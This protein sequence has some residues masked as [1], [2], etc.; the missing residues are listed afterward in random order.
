VSRVDYRQWDSDDRVS[1]E[2]FAVLQAARRDGVGFSVTDG[3]RTLAEQRD[4][5]A[6]YQRFGRPLAARPSPTAPHIRTGRPDHAIDVNA[7]DGGAGRL[8]AWLRRNGAGATFPVPGEPWHV[9]VPRDDLERL[10]RKV[11]DPFAGFT[12]KE[13]RWI[14][15]YDE[16]VRR[17]R[18]GHDTADAIEA[19]RRL[20]RLMTTR[21]KA[22]WHAAQE[23]GWDR[24]ERRTRYEALKTRTR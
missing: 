16:L 20:R 14:V 7:L 6:V 12:D 2:W 21:R 19:R 18:S 23:S 17:K 5:Y 9:E 3:H 24:L 8:A 10:A 15:S 13:R 4:R 11:S 1:T 22:I